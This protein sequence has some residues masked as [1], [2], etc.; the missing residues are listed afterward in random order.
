MTER[1]WTNPATGSIRFDPPPAGETGWTEW[2]PVGDDCNLTP[3]ALDARLATARADALREAAYVCGQIIK[4]FDVMRP[5]G[6]THQ[7]AR[8][9]RAAKGMVG[10]A[11]QD[12]LA[13]IDHPAAPQPTPEAVAR[14]ALRAAR[15]ACAPHEDDDALDRQAKAQCADAIYA[16]A[17]DPATL[18][19][20]IAK[21]ECGE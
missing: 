12:I 14:A 6:I 17:S 7:P 3:E 8:V 5:D 15:D 21:A 13:L 11:R 20:I 1:L 19:A 2:A 9:Q 10:L 16:L 18:A 4:D